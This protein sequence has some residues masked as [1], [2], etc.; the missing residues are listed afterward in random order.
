[1]MDMDWKFG[2][3]GVD[4][5]VVD[6]EDGIENQVV[7]DFLILGKEVKEENI[8]NIVRGGI[9]EYFFL[10]MILI[11]NFFVRL[12]VFMIKILKLIFLMFLLGY[13]E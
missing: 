1:M 5:L 9:I 8:I 11:L 6:L 3:M 10:I 7:V 12:F 2:I 4:L 13:F